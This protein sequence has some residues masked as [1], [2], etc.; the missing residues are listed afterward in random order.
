MYIT[1]KIYTLKTVVG[2][3]LCLNIFGDELD[4]IFNN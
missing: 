3:C 4:K 1:F 2:N